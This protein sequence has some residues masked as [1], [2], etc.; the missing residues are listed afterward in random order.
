M[1]LPAHAHTGGRAAGRVWC[2]APNRVT[3]GPGR[4][5]GGLLEGGDTRRA[6]AVHTLGEVDRRGAMSGVPLEELF[7]QMRDRGR[8]GIRG[9]AGLQPGSH[10]QEVLRLRIQDE[11]LARGRGM[12]RIPLQ[13]S[14][15]LMF[16]D[17]RLAP[18][19]CRQG[20][21]PRFRVDNAPGVHCVS[22]V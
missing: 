4:A 1:V 22:L 8:H 7:Q 14:R 17:G 13:S 15:S 21:F 5:S 16:H 3:R 10:G 18:A 11:Q 12:R 9:E 2:G 6:G 19:V 20:V